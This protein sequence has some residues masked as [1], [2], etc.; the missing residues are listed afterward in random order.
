MSLEKS[1]IYVAACKNERI[2]ILPQQL[3]KLNRP[4]TLEKVM[5]SYKADGSKMYGD[6]V[7]FDPPSQRFRQQLLL[8]ID[9]PFLWLED[10]ID[11]PDNFIDVWSVYEQNLPDDWKVAVL[12]W[13]IIYDNEDIKIRKVSPGWWH[14]E[15]G[16]INYGAFGGAHAILVN[17]GDWRLKLANREFRCDVGF[18]GALRNIGV[19]EIYH[20]D[21]ILIGTNDP[22]TTFGDLVVQYL[23]MSEPLYF[24]W[25]NGYRAVTVDDFVI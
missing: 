18:C 20:S 17:T 12:G 24:G 2:A 21:K 15:G 3:Q 10:D 1:R 5:P 16:K 25:D 9:K 6:N 11:I 13:G 14:L 4:Y 19:M 23:K 8:E 7:Y 22:Y